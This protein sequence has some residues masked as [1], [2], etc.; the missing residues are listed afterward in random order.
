MAI[1]SVCS[2]GRTTGNNKS[3]SNRRTKREIFT[4]VQTIDGVKIC[5][6]CKRTQNKSKA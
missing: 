6:R 2:R 3:H 5:T 4:N 1:C